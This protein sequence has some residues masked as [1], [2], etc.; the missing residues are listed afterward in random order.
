MCVG[1][2]ECVCGR[3]VHACV[4]GGGGVHALCVLPVCVWGVCTRVGGACV[5]VCVWC[6]RRVCVCVGVHAVCVWCV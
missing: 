2:C 4:E 6:A 3:G 5:C 1:V